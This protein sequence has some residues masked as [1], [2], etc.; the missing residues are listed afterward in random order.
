MMMISREPS[1][2]HSTKES[3][4][5]AIQGKGTYIPFV[6]VMCILLGMVLSCKK[7]SPVSFCEGVNT[8]GKGVNCGTKFSTGDLTAVIQVPERFETENLKIVVSQKTRYKNEQVSVLNQKVDYDKNTATVPLSFYIEGDYVVE[9][10]GKDDR[11]LG[12]GNIT[13]VDTY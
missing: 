6:V 7:S 12:A 8:E 9:A 1:C 2:N 10:F 3:R 11:T 5:T 4:N 13:I